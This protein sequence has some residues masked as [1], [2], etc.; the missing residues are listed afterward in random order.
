M[1]T[2]ELPVR[3]PTSWQQQSGCAASP[4]TPLLES[5]ALNALAAPGC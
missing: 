3:L 1:L 4:A 5:D 2:E